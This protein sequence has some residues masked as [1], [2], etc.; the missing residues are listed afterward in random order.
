M[1]TLGRPKTREFGG[2]LIEVS[3]NTTLVHVTIGF[4]GVGALLLQVIFAP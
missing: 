4:M 3:C 2:L 1:L